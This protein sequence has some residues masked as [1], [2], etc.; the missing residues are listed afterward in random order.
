MI[1]EVDGVLKY[2]RMA[3][4]AAGVS[5]RESFKGTLHNEKSVIVYK[6]NL[7]EIQTITSDKKLK[8]ARHPNIATLLYFTTDE[9]FRQV[10][11]NE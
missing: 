2:D 1:E 5:F 8:R 11:L 3:K 9:D 7:R 4:F 10:V 6:T